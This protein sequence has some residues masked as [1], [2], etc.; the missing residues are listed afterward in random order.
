M[1]QLVF[2]IIMRL[3]I[4]ETK[5]GKRKIRRLTEIHKTRARPKRVDDTRG[6]E[7]HNVP[8][9]GIQRSQD[10]DGRSILW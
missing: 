3:T 8:A 2:C 1:G 6:Q 5:G 7:K 10:D 9:K 4:D